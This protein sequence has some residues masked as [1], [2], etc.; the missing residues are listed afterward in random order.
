LRP[1]LFIKTKKNLS[2]NR[3]LLLAGCPGK[4]EKEKFSCDPDS[5]GGR[6]SSESFKPRPPSA[7]GFDFLGES[8]GE[9]EDIFEE[10]NR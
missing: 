8:L 1:D 10:A 7:A 5:K 6:F 3:A 2:R 9:R 4:E